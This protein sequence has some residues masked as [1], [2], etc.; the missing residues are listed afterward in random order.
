[1]SA[2]LVSWTIVRMSFD[3]CAVVTRLLAKALPSITASLADDGAAA[4]VAE[5]HSI[6]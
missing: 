5:E 4:R 3:Q 2:L 1:M 6:G